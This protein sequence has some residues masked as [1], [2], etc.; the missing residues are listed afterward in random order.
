MIKVKCPRCKELFE[1]HDAY[2]GK[3]AQCPAC[4]HPVSIPV[5]SSARDLA[6]PKRKK[7]KPSLAEHGLGIAGV[8]LNIAAVS[9]LIFG[10]VNIARKDADLVLPVVLFPAFCL[11][12]TGDLFLAIHEI[13]RYLRRI[14]V[15][16]E[17]GNTP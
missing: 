2:A 17:K 7:E 1:A 10:F 11:F 9:W 13:L 6:P 3:T 4:E 14:T 16:L 15:A 12:V 5:P 8:L